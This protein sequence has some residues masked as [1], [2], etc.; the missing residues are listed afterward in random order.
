MNIGRNTLRQNRLNKMKIAIKQ[1]LVLCWFIITQWF[2]SFAKPLSDDF[3]NSTNQYIDDNNMATKQNKPKQ[4]IFVTKPIAPN[5]EDV[6][7]VK[8]AITQQPSPSSSNN[9]LK[10]TASESVESNYSVLPTNSHQENILTTTVAAETVVEESVVQQPSSNNILEK[11]N[12]ACKS[13][14]ESNWTAPYLAINQE[15]FHKMMD[16]ILP[17]LTS[18][19]D[20][21]LQA[22]HR[23][24]LKTSRV[25][26]NGE[27]DNGELREFVADVLTAIV[28]EIIYKTEATALSERPNG[29]KLI[30]APNKKQNGNAVKIVNGWSYSKQGDITFL[31][32]EYDTHLEICCTEPIVVLYSGK[33][34]SFVQE[35]YNP[36]N[37][38]L[39]Y[40]SFF[41]VVVLTSWRVIIK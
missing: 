27:L 14:V 5:D 21:Q 39:I 1:R 7:D 18:V 31:Y 12:I 30:I 28:E 13:V 3:N 9:L 36:M 24:N 37:P 10:D 38:Q 20:F 2:R 29:C 8:E 4:S 34:M 22:N 35:M 32:H 26:H 17:D 23:L 15:N 19:I 25:F 33:L 11:F 40:G 6:V 16:S 41:D